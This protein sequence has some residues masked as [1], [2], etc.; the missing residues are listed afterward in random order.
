M[1]FL[2]TS[3]SADMFGNESLSKHYI[4]FYSTCAY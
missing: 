3:V 1:S 4:L 2:S